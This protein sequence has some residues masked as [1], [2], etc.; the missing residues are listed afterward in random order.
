MEYIVIYKKIS[1]QIVRIIELTSK[2]VSWGYSDDCAEARTNERPT[3]D[4]FK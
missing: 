2:V 3:G 1:K 4:F